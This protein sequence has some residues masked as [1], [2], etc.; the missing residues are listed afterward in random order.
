MSFDVLE[1][2]EV[3]GVE[4]TDS[5]VVTETLV[6]NDYNILKNQPQIEGVKLTGNKTIKDLGIDKAIDTQVTAK[7]YQ[8]SAQVESAI[9]SKGYQTSTQVESAITGKGYQTA[10]QVENTIA[11]KGYQT[12]SQVNSAITSKGYVTSAQV[13]SQ[14]ASKGYQTASQVNATVGNATKGLITETSL[15][16]TTIYKGADGKIHAQGGGG[17]ASVWGQITGT[18]SNQTDL[19]NALNAKQATLVSGTNIKTVNGTSLLGNGNIVI[20]KGDTGNSGVYIGATE[21]TDPNVNVWICPDGEPD[22][23]VSKSEV[24][25]MI[26]D[27]IWGALNGNY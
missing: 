15:D 19:Q 23:F 2:A 11:S 13:D 3:Y 14:I 26:N 1:D 22:E 25:Q 12:S 9:T 5:V 6:E 24:E 4:I 16:G 7:G 18:L 27:A 17:G 10:Q 20:P 8:T 21:P